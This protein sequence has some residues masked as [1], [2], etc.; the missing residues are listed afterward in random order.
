MGGGGGAHGERAE[1]R[2][3]AVAVEKTKEGEVVYAEV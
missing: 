3:G 2:R 1:E